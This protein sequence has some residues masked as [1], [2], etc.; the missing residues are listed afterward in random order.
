[1]T[2]KRYLTEA[3]QKTLLR[4]LRLQ[5]GDLLARRDFAWV[6]A[7]IHSGMRIGEFSK[8]TVGDVLAALRTGWLFVPKEHRKGKRRDH[9]V[10]LTAPLRT[11]LQ[12]LLAVRADMTGCATHSEDAPLVLS[13]QGGAMTVR[14]YEH[15][16]RHWA[17]AAG[18]TEPVTPHWL[19]HTRAKNIMRNTTS[20]DPR[21]IVQRA[22]G[23]S[24]IASTGIYTEVDGEEL[25]EALHEVDAP[26]ADR[27]CIKRG[28]RKAYEG[29]AA[30]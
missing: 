9:E 19:R 16:M 8:V 4:T 25:A 13:R 12:D 5:S 30:A 18:I 26:H 17:E 27:R 28:L 1:M 14:Q 21:G 23:H 20:K 29:R 6:R 11:A 15:R 10:L 22:L 3:Q 24:S 2:F 7:L